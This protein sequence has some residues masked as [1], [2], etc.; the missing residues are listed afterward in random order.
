M[1]FLKLYQILSVVVQSYCTSLNYAVI[2]HSSCIS[3]TLLV[4]G[5]VRLWLFLSIWCYLI[6]VLIYIFPISGV[7]EHIFI[8][9][10]SIWVSWSINC[11]SY[12]V[13]FFFPAILFLSYR[14]SLYILETS[15]FSVMSNANVF[16][17]IY[18]L[19]FCLYCLLWCQTSKL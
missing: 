12:L 18:H 17:S 6:V 13:L 10:L 7:A 4:V 1:S 14:S 8:H 5:S 15:S 19:S 9:L 2:C 16:S 3:A 11:F